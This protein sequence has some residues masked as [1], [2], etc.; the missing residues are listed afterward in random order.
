MEHTERATRCP[1][2][3]RVRGTRL[4]R[5]RP[6]VGPSRSLPCAG[7]S[8]L[9]R[10]ER[11]SASIWLPTVLGRS[12]TAV[13]SRMRSQVCVTACGRH[14]RLPPRCL[15]A[16]WQA[17]PHSLAPR[18]ARACVE[19]RTR[20]GSSRGCRGGP[21]T[22]CTCFTVTDAGRW[23]LRPW[24]AHLPVRAQVPCSGPVVLSDQGLM[25]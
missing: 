19:I 9:R 10:A 14:S 23:S 16:S 18:R 20:T 13:P 3:Q 21:P 6:Q 15:V 17:P 1:G 11:C 8:S 2:P 25:S 22:A 7:L 24:G 5:P 12:Q 4:S